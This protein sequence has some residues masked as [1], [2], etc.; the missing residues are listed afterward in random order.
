M[1]C[2]YEDVCKDLDDLF[3]VET[4]REACSP[5]NCERYDA[6]FEGAHW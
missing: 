3:E 1:K 4:D 5:E 6:I 2:P